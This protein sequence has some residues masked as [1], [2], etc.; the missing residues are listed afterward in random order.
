MTV[1]HTEATLVRKFD[2]PAEYRDIATANYDRSYP[3]ESVPMYEEILFRHST[4]HQIVR[5]QQT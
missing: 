1:D 4:R 3:P 2:S 5:P